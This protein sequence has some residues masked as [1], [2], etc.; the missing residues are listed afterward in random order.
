VNCQ[1]AIDVMGEAAEGRLEAALQA[2][3]EEHMA[4]CSPCGTYFEHLRLTREAL[5]LLPRGGDT[6]PRRAELMERFAKE[7]D[8][9]GT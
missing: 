5:Q 2:G 6:S 8:H 7:F 1:E 3:F 9:D 4:E